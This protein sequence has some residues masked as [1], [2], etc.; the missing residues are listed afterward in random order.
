MC[1]PGHVT[2]MCQHQEWVFKSQNLK[3]KRD[4]IDILS[5]P[6]H[7][8]MKKTQNVVTPGQTFSWCQLVTEL[9]LS[10]L[11]TTPPICPHY[12]PCKSLEQM[13]L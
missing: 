9:R 10:L 2:R 6:P 4:L 11:P 12:C 5:H 13:S 7:L 8:Q 1:V 3:N